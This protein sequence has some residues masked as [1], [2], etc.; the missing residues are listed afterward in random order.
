MMNLTNRGLALLQPRLASPH[1]VLLFV[2]L[3][4]RVCFGASPAALLG[5]KKGKHP[6]RNHRQR[7]ATALRGCLQGFAT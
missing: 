4:T 2:H 6:H 3:A 1:L 5:T 7:L